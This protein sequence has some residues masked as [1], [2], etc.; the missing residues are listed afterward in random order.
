MKMKIVNS[1]SEEWCGKHIRFNL[2]ME[3]N[4]LKNIETG[5]EEPNLIYEGDTIINEGDTI[6]ND[7]LDI[8]TN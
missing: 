6:I 7:N 3:D 4:I 8:E 2:I 1:K 5:E